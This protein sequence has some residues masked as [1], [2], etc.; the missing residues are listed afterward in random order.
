MKMRTKRKS[1]FKNISAVNKWKW[2]FY[3]VL[4]RGEDFQQK[5]T[6]GRLRMTKDQ[7]IRNLAMIG[8]YFLSQINYTVEGYI[9]KKSIYEK[10][11]EST[12][13]KNI[14]SHDYRTSNYN[15]KKHDYFGLN[16]TC[17]LVITG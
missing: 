2:L 16:N 11:L 13:L 15:I 17:I 7:P 10:G 5:S 1:I 3:H 4:N 8:N 9:S 14:K 6:S 12:S